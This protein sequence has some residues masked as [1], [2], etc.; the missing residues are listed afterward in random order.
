MTLKSRRRFT[1]KKKEFEKGVLGEGFHG[2]TYRV[3]Y[4]N[5]RGN[6]LYNFIDQ[7]NIITLKLYTL[8]PQDNV[9]MKDKKDIDEFLNYL[10][11]QKK[12][13][14]I[15]K[16]FKSTFFITGTTTKQDLEQELDAN[17]NVIKH[18]GNV[19]K[20]YLT[21]SPIT[22]FRNLKII[23]AHIEIAKRANLYMT[24]STECHNKYPM[25][26]DKFIIEILESIKIVQEAKYQ[27]NDIKLD[28]IVLCDNRYKLIDWGQA[29]PLDKINFGDMLYSNPIKWYIMG[30]PKFIAKSLMSIGG[31]LTNRNYKGSEIFQNTNKAINNEVD[32]ILQTVPETDKLLELYKKTFDVFMVGMTLIHAIY[33][34]KLNEEKY[35][36]LAKK[37]ISIIN[38]VKDAEE[39]LKFAK[40]YLKKY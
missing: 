17:I 33:K 21:I 35:L 26:A 8:D 37:L 30:A 22:G 25:S 15:A 39:A 27:H 31:T 19:A 28:N 1:K 12:K 9:T 32:I 5:K 23:G 3:G 7:E 16:I 14:I 29:G 13:N 10:H 34:F 24:F 4:N 18:F 11:H 20:K 36:P 40:D 38:P 6:S 2:K